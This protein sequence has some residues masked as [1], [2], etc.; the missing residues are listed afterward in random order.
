[1]G[2]AGFEP[3]KAYANGFTARPLWPLRYSPAHTGR[4]VSAARISIK[5]PFSRSLEDPRA[6]EA[7]GGSKGLGFISFN[8]GYG[9]PWQ[10]GI[11]S[12][13]VA[14]TIDGT[15]VETCPADLDDN[16][17]VG[18]LDLLTLLANWGPCA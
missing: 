6:A 12:A 1:M 3:A 4:T 17:S 8:L 14:T 7:S 10:P 18:I 2:E 15:P 16:G 11:Q 9:D 5:E 13:V